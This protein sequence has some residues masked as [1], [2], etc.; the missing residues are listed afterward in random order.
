MKIKTKLALLFTLIT[1]TLLLFFA[2]IIYFSVKNNREKEFYA[3]LKQEAITKANLFLELKVDAHTLQNI[4]QNNRQ[5]INEVEVAIYNTNLK[6]LYHDNVEV[7]MIE[8]SPTFLR[9]IKTHG[10]LTRYKNKWQIIGL[11]YKINDK[12]YVITAAAYD[13]YGYNV[14]DSLLKTCIFVLVVS[15]FL[16]IPAAF[17][18][19]KKALDPVKEMTQKAQLISASNLDLRLT[20]EKN[21]D[22][23][24][25]LAST[26]NEM[27]NRLENSFEAQKNF[28]SNISHELRTPLAAII[29][30][31]ELTNI[32]NKSIDEYK[33]A[34]HN[35]LN[36][37]Q[38]IV[39][40]INNLFDLAKASYDP[41]KIHRK[42]IRVD[43]L[44]L[45]AVHQVQQINNN[46][47][48]D[49]SFKKFPENEEDLHIY[50]NEYLLKVCFVNLMENACK[51][52]DNACCEVFIDLDEAFFYFEFKDKGI[53][54][55]SDDLPYIFNS[56]YRGNNQNFNSGHG[57]GL[58]LTQKIIELHQG[59]ISVTSKVN[60]G[61]SFL[62]SIAKKSNF[63]PF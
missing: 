56:F 46:Y 23:L 7:N 28:V 41:S 6:L 49:L 47:K 48:I 58:S 27:L 51:F 43:E 34:V 52:S 63:Y 13:E 26:F 17:Y 2:S 38:K 35:S 3:L 22:E 32:K 18:F 60:I 57:I 36:D 10:E 31:L 62:I 44:L 4:Y 12:T 8:Q 30:E 55:N 1:T 20:T 40:L 16:I 37:A 61:T 29:T 15:L 24:A 21:E 59:K 54:I 42:L 50:A 39:R 11:N 9:Q 25:E 14:L 33:I 53:G 5:T 19:T 45:D